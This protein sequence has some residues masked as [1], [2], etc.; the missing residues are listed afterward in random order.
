MD[1]IIIT[2]VCATIIMC[3]G[4]ITTIIGPFII[5]IIIAATIITI[6]GITIL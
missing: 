6:D 1:G 2:P 5:I 4:C 3:L